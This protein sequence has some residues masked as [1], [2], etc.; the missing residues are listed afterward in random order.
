MKI[1]VVGTGYVGLV[2]GTC[3]ADLG[4]QVTCA[5]TDQSK[6]DALLDGR[7]P[8]YEPG[9]DVV[10]AR[11]VREHRLHFTTRTA[12]A[13]AASEVIYIAVGTPG[14]PDGSA[15]LSGVLAVSDII[16][17]NATRPVVVIIKS[18]V[19]VGTADIVRDRIAQNI[20][21]E[22]DVVSNPEF[23]KEGAAIDDFSRPDRIVV[24]CRTE[25]ARTVME[26]LYAGL[27]RSGRPILFMDN[28]SAEL[29]KYASNAMLAT[30]ISFMNELSRL[31]ELVGADIESIRRGTGTDSRIG[32]R[33]LF[34][35]AGYGGSCFPKDVNALIKTAEQAGLHLQLASAVVAVNDQQKHVMADKVLSRFGAD[36]TG[37]TF[38]MWG[39]AFKPDTDD[40]R[41]APSVI[42]SRRLIAAGARI[43]AYDPEAMHEARHALGDTITYAES[44][45][46]ALD[47]ADALLLV[48][49]W[50]EFRN[51]EWEQVRAA[52][53]EP[54]VFDGRNIYDPDDVRGAGLEYT[55]IGRR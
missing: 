17:K 42:I 12:E 23:L 3:M 45:M 7:I 51:P 10:L 22:F 39:L 19:P 20:R 47:G 26:K 48:T 18:T 33:F 53:K 31:C 36:L 41:E 24:G 6:I 38:A 4:F 13:V 1:C 49:E 40:M 2:V 29:T 44:A 21:H 54:V 30:R 14:L 43:V 9:L 25:R 34:A 55:G 52:L 35:G 8:I 16:A 28:R 27:V 37:R 50:S 5:D 32:P 46:D 15:D 11:N